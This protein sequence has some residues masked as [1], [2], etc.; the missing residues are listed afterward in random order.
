MCLTTAK[1]EPGKGVG[2]FTKGT[3]EL[4]PRSQRAGVSRG[5]QAGGRAVRPRAGTGQLET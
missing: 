2:Y 5:L 4:R 3:E 1:S